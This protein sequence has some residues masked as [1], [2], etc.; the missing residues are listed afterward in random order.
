[1]RQVLVEAIHNK[2]GDVIRYPLTDGTVFEIPAGETVR[3]EWRIEYDPAK[4]GE[5]TTP[6]EIWFFDSTT[7]FHWGRYTFP[8]IDPQDTTP[9]PYAEYRIIA[10]PPESLGGPRLTLIENPDTGPVG[11]AFGTDPAETLRRLAEPYADDL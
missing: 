8:H 6:N 3:G 10:Y 11:I 9:A 7:D 4:H 1:M 5:I 2:T